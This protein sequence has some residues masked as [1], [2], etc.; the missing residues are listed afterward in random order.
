MPD[1]AFSRPITILTHEF[2]PRRG[3]IATFCEEIALAAHADGRAIE[4]WTHLDHGGRARAWPFP[5]RRLRM[6]GTHGP[7]CRLATL[8]AFVTERARLREAIVLLA[9]P[10]PMLAAMWLTPVPA[11][12]PPRLAL[13]FHGSEILRFARDPAIRPLARALIQRAFRINTLTHY[14]RDLLCAHFPEATGKTVLTPGAV[15]DAALAPA[16][17]AR[18]H[19]ASRIVVLTVGRLHPR[20]GQ[21]QTLQALDALPPALRERVDYWIVGKASS[22]HHEHLLRLAAAATSVRTRFW[23]EL[24]E[25]QLDHVYRQ[26]DVFAL[27]SVAHGSSIEGF[28]LVYLEASARGLPIVAHRIGGVAEAVADGVTGLLVAPERPA[29]LTAAFARLIEA[30]EL[31]RRLGAAGPEWARKNTWAAAARALFAP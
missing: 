18:D 5:V 6:R 21:L 14:T 28:G 11:L 25:T 24:N 30:P 8:R 4:V 2:D 29:G 23:G 3:G 13:T 10:G 7:R 27:T 12:L 20:K 22:A 31:R 16:A 1:A 9:E 15:R 17:P 19:A 26:A